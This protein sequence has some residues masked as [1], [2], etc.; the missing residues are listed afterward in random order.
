MNYVWVYIGIWDNLECVFVRVLS[1]TPFL[2]PPYS[3]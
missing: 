1:S 2:M 3:Q